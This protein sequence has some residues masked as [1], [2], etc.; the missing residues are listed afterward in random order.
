MSS[1]IVKIHPKLAQFVKTSSEKVKT[2]DSIIV[3]PSIEMKYINTGSTVL[4]MLIGGTRLRSGKFLCPGYPKGTIIE[5]FGKEGSGKST[6]ALMAMGQAI[7]SENETGCGLYVDLEHAVK[8][9]YA[10]KLGC[11]FRPPEAGGHGRAMRIA[12]RTFEETEALVNNA[13]MSGV[14]LIAVDSV[15]GLIPRG[16]AARNVMDEKDKSALAEVPRLMSAWLP[17]LQSIISRSGTIVI[18]LNQTRDKIG[19]MTGYTEESK[20]STVGGNALKFWT[21]IRWLLT[22]K[23]VAKAKV[24]NPLINSYEELPI[25]TKVVVKNVKNKID[26]RQG[27][28]GLVTLRYGTGIDELRTMLDIAI[29]YKIIESSKNGLKQDVFTFSSAKNKKNNLKCIGIEKLRAELVKKDNMEIYEEVMES[30]K[31]KLLEGFKMPDDDALA[32]LEESAIK[33]KIHSDDDDEDEEGLNFN[34]LEVDPSKYGIGEN[35][36]DIIPADDQ[37]NSQ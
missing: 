9:Y 25:A 16:E 7:M 34:P 4:N 31:E 18:F 32:S 1:K 33:T 17:K 15:A 35:G 5:V 36:E 20:K 26:A 14:D 12:P 27:Y 23:E 10:I 28:S 11:D 19:Q 13:A 2:L 24:F 8:D 37:E 21:S 3:K 22:P 30:C 6:V 29:I